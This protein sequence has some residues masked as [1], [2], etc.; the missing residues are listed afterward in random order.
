V[1]RYGAV[2]PPSPEKIETVVKILEMHY[3]RE[4]VCLLRSLV[5]V[6]RG[7]SLGVVSEVAF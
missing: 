4:E 5:A 7:F 1:D 3:D 6:R 2:A